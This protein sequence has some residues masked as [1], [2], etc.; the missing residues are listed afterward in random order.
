MTT[1]E[2][3]PPVAPETPTVVH[4]PTPADRRAARP[5]TRLTSKGWPLGL[6]LAAVAVFVVYQYVYP[7]ASDSFQSFLDNWLSMSAINECVI[8]VIFAL[9]LNVVVGYAGLLDLGYV[10]FWALGGYFAGWVMSPFFHQVKFSILGHPL[11]GQEQGIHI[12]FWIA[13]P[14]AGCYCALW[15]LL[16]GA[17]TLRLKS[18]YLAIVTLGFGEII[19]QFFV[20][21]QNL[22]GFNLTN[23]VQGITPVDPIGT[24]PLKHLGLP[25][26][27]GPFNLTYKFVVFAVM[28]A[29]CMFVS[30]R[31]RQGRL[32]RAWLAIR[33]DE[34]AA[35]MMGVPLMRSKLAAY[36]VGAFAGGLG[37]VLYAEHIGGVIPDQFKF[38]IS[39]TLLAMVVL[40][41]M[42]NVWGVTIG[43]LVLAWINNT[44]LSQVGSTV[45]S[46]LHTNINFPS[47]NFLIFG[48]IL[49]GMM[50]FR[51]EGLI[52]EMR[53]RQ[54][55]QEP[56]RGEIESVGADLESEPV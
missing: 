32:G 3:P 9:G 5:W 37:G 21:G 19:P 52:P 14:L 31:I 16:I 28:A 53:T 41:G 49:V 51:R 34:L 46:A 44:G 15:G 22:H 23:G 55:L 11:P 38:A 26:Y 48:A 8:W 24:G 10:A 36:S 29:L 45:N 50:L 27:L 33:E 6:F 20:N 13:L 42:G 43:A 54:L 17:P 56:E 2:T 12:N 30:L 47:Y 7:N 40:G 1:S 25:P 39:I 18:D 4:T 35:S